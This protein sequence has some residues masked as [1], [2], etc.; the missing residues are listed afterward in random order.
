MKRKNLARVI[1]VYRMIESFQ[2]GRKDSP[3]MREL[4]EIGVAHSSSVISYYYDELVELGM[5]ERTERGGIS[6]LPLAI[7]APEIRAII[8]G[9]NG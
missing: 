8:G 1:E 4:M 7:A 3:T 5:A 6:L 9:G 2:K